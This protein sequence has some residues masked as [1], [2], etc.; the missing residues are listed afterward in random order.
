MKLAIIFG[1]LCVLFLFVYMFL[2]AVVTQ[3]PL[4]A[5][6]LT[7]PMVLTSWGTGAF[8]ILAIVCL[9]IKR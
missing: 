1:I 3:A 9:L 4:L 7:I 6:V 8:F 2:I 5:M